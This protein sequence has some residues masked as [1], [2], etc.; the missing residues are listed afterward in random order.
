MKVSIKVGDTDVQWI[1]PL[2]EWIVVGDLGYVIGLHGVSKSFQAL[3]IHHEG[4][5]GAS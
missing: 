4:P 2:D 3:D 1:L 5:L